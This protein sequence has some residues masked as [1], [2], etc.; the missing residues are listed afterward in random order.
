MSPYVLMLWWSLG[1]QIQSKSLVARGLGLTCGLKGKCL[2]RMIGVWAGMLG[3]QIS[4]LM[5]LQKNS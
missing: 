3:L 2:P 5:S 4:L 1:K